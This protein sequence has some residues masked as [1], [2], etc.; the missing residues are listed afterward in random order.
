MVIYRTVDSFPFL[1]SGNFC[2][3]TFILF[4]FGV[5]IAAPAYLAYRLLYDALAINHIL[6]SAV[7]AL[8]PHN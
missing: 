6:I 4:L 7:Y 2:P 1:S 3:L 8:H 5:P